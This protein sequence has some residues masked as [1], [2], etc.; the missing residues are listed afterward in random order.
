MG[1]FPLK[2]WAVEPVNTEGVAMRDDRVMLCR[3]EEGFRVVE[4]RRKGKGWLSRARCA[5]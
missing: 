1:F 2:G 3:A 5:E 4:A